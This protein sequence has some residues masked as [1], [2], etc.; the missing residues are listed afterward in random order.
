MATM[1][2]NE[3]TIIA[4][5]PGCDGARSTFEWI[6]KGSELGAITKRVDDR[7][8][9][10]CML[11]FRLFRCAGCGIGALGVIKYDGGDRYPGLKNRLLR[12]VP[13]AKTRLPLPHRAPREIVAEFREAER[14]LEINCLRAAAGMFHSVL[15]KTMRANGYGSTKE[16]HLRQQIDSA[17]KDGVITLARKKRL[18]ADLHAIGCDLA[19]KEPGKL[20]E[21][22]LELARRSCQRVLEDFYD[23]RESVFS[24][25]RDAGRI[26]AEGKNKGTKTKSHQQLSATKKRTATADGRRQKI[27][28]QRPCKA[29]AL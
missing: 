28:P 21:I 25:L 15:V 6:H 26:V 29:G 14:C 24:L 20:T 3:G 17:A 10:E 27:A 5:C 8:W 7:N 4:R 12:F 23:D 2:K 9:R 22:E 1:N 11:D 18:H 16:K 13:E 19:Q